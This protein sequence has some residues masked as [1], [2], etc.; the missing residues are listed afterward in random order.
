MYTPKLLTEIKAYSR[1]KALADL[2]AGMTVGVVALPLAMAFAIASGLPP[3]RGLFTAIVAGFPDDVDFGQ[4][5]R[6]NH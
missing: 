5:A 2:F 3:E 1:E 6:G 4:D